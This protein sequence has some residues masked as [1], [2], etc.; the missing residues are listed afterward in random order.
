MA[1][2]RG[3]NPI[4]LLAGAMGFVAVLLGIYAAQLPAYAEP[5]PLPW[6]LL[7]ALFYLAEVR[8]VHL[9]FQR[10]AHSYSLSELPLV[11]GLFLAAPGE[12]V[13][14]YTLGAA[15]G[16]V[17][18][19]RPPP[20]K[21]AF[22]VALFGLN[23]GVAVALFHLLMPL[24]GWGLAGAWV[25][26]F[27]TT[28]TVTLLGLVLINVAIRLAQGRTD[29]RR[30]APAIQFGLSV[31]VLNTAL[32]LVGVTLFLQQPE[33]PW[34]L[35]VPLLLI[36]LTWRAYRTSMSDRQNRESL[37][38]LYETN[39]I[40]HDGDR[41]LED[42]IVAL[43]TEARRTFRAEYAE[44]ILFTAEGRTTGLRT[45]LG[46][47]EEVDMLA[48][49]RLDP[50][51][52]ALRLEAIAENTAFRAPRLSPPASRTDRV[53]GSPISDAM[54]APLRGERTILGTIMMAN[55]QGELGTFRPEE[56]QLFE[57][58]A[59]HASV[60]LEN[61]QL[62]RSLKDL[63]EL[64]DRLSYQALHDDLTGLGNRPQLVD[65]LDD[66][67]SRG[68][69]Q[70]NVPVVVFIDLD[71]FKSVN[72]TFGHA[73]GNE[74]LKSV[75]QSIV[76][77]IRPTDVAARLS[78][79]EFVVLM[80]DG[81]DI[82][83]VIRVAERILK[84]VAAPIELAGVTI[85]VTASVGIAAGRTPSQDAEELLHE[86]DVAM[87]T[88]KTRGKGRF[89][90]FDP[91]LEL[92]LNER[93]Q[94]RNELAGVVSRNELTLQYQP[95][96]D[97]RTGDM[98]GLEALVR[99]RHP[100]R[101]E[102]APGDFIPI[103]EES[104]LIVPIGRWIMRQACKQA[105]RWVSAGAEPLPI[106]VNVSIH[107]LL[108][109][110]FVDD[111]IAITSLSGLAP[112]LL[113]LEFKEGQIMTD[114]PLVANRLHQLKA[115]GVKIAI[116]GFG[117]GYS[118]L[119]SLGRY[120]IDVIKVARPL[121]AASGRAAEDQRIAEAVVALG[122]SLHLQVVAEGIENVAQLDRMRIA[123]CDRGQGFLF[124][125]PMDSD[126]V[127]KLLGL[128]PAGVPLTAAAAA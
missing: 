89:A 13:F 115:V 104:G 23:A 65:R 44:L 122:H 74:L 29:P 62:G 41:E 52:D 50:L 49:I 80:E 93:Q 117:G 124:A 25:A 118:S 127:D 112:S 21:L 63:S 38:L 113:T 68:R 57:T 36:A 15:A 64:K 110:D 6:W 73:V 114:E 66:A 14:A 19:R 45:I 2:V 91:D 61:G 5:S 8:V 24:A 105:R 34:L 101:G 11:V 32:A 56:L 69:R 46:P 35:V 82:G 27:V 98:V 84:A 39:G 47:H 77:A 92:E 102:L 59:S 99:W 22:N 60:A 87:Y 79:D 126:G 9:Q 95:I 83:A 100:E 7:T 75:A 16:L 128:E 125:R 76:G 12:L 108:D 28:T 116:D 96:T 90:V 72:D 26:A 103:A 81:R 37:E 31:S 53:K 4:W 58:L 107:Q 119:R 30:L 78:G 40:L 43:L 17:I 42:A 121:I 51:L 106:S 18:H 97:L 67:L 109:P 3:S 123:S 94:L 88:A 20:L 71:D 70:G 54:V 33:A 48:T 55:R 120:P 85:S 1:S 86:A 111:V 10:E